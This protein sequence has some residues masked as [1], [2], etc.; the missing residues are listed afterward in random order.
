MTSP[1]PNLPVSD[2]GAS[3]GT[4]GLLLPGM[5]LGASIFPPLPFPTLALDFNRVP[6]TDPDR[7]T[8][9]DYARTLRDFLAD[10][11]AWQTA[12]RRIIVAHSF[13]GMLALH[14]LSSGDDCGVDGVVLMAT[15]AGPMYDVVRL[16]LPGIRVPLA[17]AMGVWRL[18][19]MTRLAKTILA[20][21]PTR[22]VDFRRI[23]FTSDAALDL[24][25]WRNT[26]AEAMRAYRSAMVG[27]D[28]RDRLSRI[29]IPAVVL[30]GTRDALFPVDVARDL[31][32]GL[33]NA[34]LEIVPGAGHGLPITHGETVVGAV[35]ELI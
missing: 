35:R 5:S 7:V 2:P 11:A 1:E 14:W 15:T 19:A 3:P 10:A 4:V 30:H 13:G 17:P 20:P 8:M 24:Y 33:P 6:P 12:R 26:T 29:T 9:T 28:V 22:D 25:G 16:K 23:R 34:R 18:P 27:F 21:G 31:A 32:R